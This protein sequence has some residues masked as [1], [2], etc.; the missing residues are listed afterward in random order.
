MARPQIP[1]KRD[2]VPFRLRRM[3]CTNCMLS[4]FW[5]ALSRNP[6]LVVRLCVPEKSFCMWSL[7]D[8]GHTEHLLVRVSDQI[9][10]WSPDMK[11]GFVTPVVCAIGNFIFLQKVSSSMRPSICHTLNAFFDISHHVT[12]IVLLGM[13]VS[14]GGMRLLEQST[15]ATCKLILPRPRGETPSTNMNSDK[16]VSSCVHGFIF[17]AALRSRK[18]QTSTSRRDLVSSPLNK[19]S[20]FFFAC[21]SSPLVHCK[22]QQSRCETRMWLRVIPIPC[23]TRIATPS[24]GM[25]FLCPHRGVFGIFDL[26][27]LRHEDSNGMPISLGSPL[28]RPNSLRTI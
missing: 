13:S 23:R 10:W 20:T 3:G 9:K 8:Q 4:M 16:R 21:K 6:G 2:T 12:S 24:A 14:M 11:Y 18:K 1:K 26:Y 15:M 7:R 25:S 22:V 17:L 28:G 5:A 19:G 27:L